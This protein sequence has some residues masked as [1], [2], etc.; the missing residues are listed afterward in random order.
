MKRN[1]SVLS[2]AFAAGMTVLIAQGPVLG[3]ENS[4][5]DKEIRAGMEAVPLDIT[6]NLAGKNRNL[7]YLGSYYVNGISDCAGCHNAPN[8]PM[9]PKPLRERYLAGGAQFGPVRSR[10]LTPDATGKPSGLTFSQFRVAMRQGRDWDNLP[11]IVGNPDTLIVMP[12]Q[13]Y[14]HGTEAFLKAI[15]EYLRA[16]PCVPGGPKPDSATRCGP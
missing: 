13:A 11:P 14:N 16:L 7:V 2:A 8:D 5:V 4:S 3:Q 10:N 1:L 12:W 6:L 15:Y 9:N